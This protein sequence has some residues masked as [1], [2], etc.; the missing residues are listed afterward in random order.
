MGITK[1]G[2]HVDHILDRCDR[3]D[4]A[5]ADENL[6]TKCES[7][8]NRKT[9]LTMAKRRRGRRNGQTRTT[10]ETDADAGD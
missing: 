3:P 9:A 7:H 5:F 2:E 8:H 1:V 10:T 4:L 6:S